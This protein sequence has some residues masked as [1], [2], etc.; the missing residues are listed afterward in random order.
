MITTRVAA[1]VALASG[2]LFAS[3]SLAVAQSTPVTEGIPCATA[4]SSLP[5]PIALS[6][7]E[8]YSRYR[9]LPRV[10][11]FDIVLNAGEGLAANADA[12][13]AFRE[14]WEGARPGPSRNARRA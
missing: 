12:L 7:A 8:L 11:S 3:S 5:A 13:A 1:I 2:C 9:G 4:E 14:W 10:G 6:S